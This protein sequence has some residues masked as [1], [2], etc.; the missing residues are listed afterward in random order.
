MPGGLDHGQPSLAAVAFLD[1]V[2]AADPAE[3]PQR[4]AAGVLGVHPFLQVEVHR[5]LQV[6]AQFR[7]EVVVETP[8]AEEPYQ[9]AAKHS[10]R[11][12]HGQVSS[13]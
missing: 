13:S 10:A 3:L 9:A 11:F 2:D 6:R 12:A 5:H 1:P 4:V 7:I 8:L